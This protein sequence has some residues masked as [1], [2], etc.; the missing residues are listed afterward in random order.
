LRTIQRAGAAGLAE[1]DLLSAVD[2]VGGVLAA[3]LTLLAQD[4][5]IEQVAGR[6]KAR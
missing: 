2:G 4:G 1:G 6:W 3:A 5:L